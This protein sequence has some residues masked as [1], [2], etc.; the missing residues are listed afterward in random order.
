MSVSP[1]GGTSP[2]KLRRW[3]VEAI[4]LALASLEAGN[5]GV[6]VAT[7]GA[8]KSIA[9][10]EM[11]RRWRETHPES[12]GKIV[13]TT[14]SKKLVNQLA[15]TFASVLG[16]HLVGRFFTSAKQWQRPI[17]VCCNASVLT[18]AEVLRANGERVAVWVADEVHKTQSDQFIVGDDDTDA[19]DDG[20]VADALSAER[21]LGFTATPFRSNAAQTLTLFDRVVYLYPPADAL[22]DGVIVPWRVVGWDES[23]TEADD[24]DAV[25]A[26]LITELGDRAARGP[27]VVNATTIEDAEGYVRYLGERGIEARPI[28]SRLRDTEQKANLAALEAGEIDCLVH[29]SMLV[30]GVDYPWLRWGCLRRPVGARVRFIQEVG[31]FIRACPEIGKTEAVLLDPHDLFGT[32]QLTYE[33]ALGWA[34][35]PDIDPVVEEEDRAI[36]ES[37]P[38]EPKDRRAARTSALGRY[39]RQLYI[40]LLAEGRAA[41]GKVF[42]AASAGWRGDDPSPQQA[43]AFRALAK[44]SAGRLA[45]PHRSAIQRIAATPAAATK[46]IASDALSLLD[47]L[48]AVVLGEWSPASPVPL[49]PDAAFDA[50]AMPADDRWYAAGGL[51][52]GRVASVLVHSGEVIVNASREAQPGDT[53]TTLTLY[54]VY[55]AVDKHGATSVVVGDADTAAMIAGTKSPTR[56]ARDYLSRIPTSTRVEVEKSNP[57][58]RLVWKALPRPA[59]TE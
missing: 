27:G 1:S 42:G 53:W 52:G 26:L 13:V 30:E 3:Q 11:L 5:N 57:A 47:G 7:T 55:Q 10:A 54:A 18:L 39:V 33:A 56:K 23:R 2:L 44:K 6:I 48:S 36:K 28:H 14:P 21:R 34:E 4:P 49:P 9:L 8:G 51:R 31:R 50:V 19:T 22:R 16:G 25:C 17:V 43:R 37:E 46:G 24:P 58:V 15:G 20:A 12:E 38:K 45:E 41:Q 40:A 32:F 35:E 59:A 29:V